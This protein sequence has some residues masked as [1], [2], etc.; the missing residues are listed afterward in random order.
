MSLFKIAFTLIFISILI[1]LL[2][3]NNNAIDSQVVASANQSIINKPVTS[4]EV[5]RPVTHQSAHFTIT[6]DMES[7]IS[8][9]DNPPFKYKKPKETPIDTRAIKIVRNA[10]NNIAHSRQH[11]H[12]DHEHAAFSRPA[13]EPKPAN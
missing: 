11:G 13:G 4:T 10:Q 6:Q 1:F 3:P 8:A 7:E 12:E 5:Q 2:N 9:V